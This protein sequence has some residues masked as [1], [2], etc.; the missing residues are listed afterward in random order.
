MTDPEVRV[1]TQSIE[2]D[3]AEVY[4]FLA[5]PRNFAKWASGLGA[6]LEPSGTEWTAQGPEGPVRIRF[7]PRNE[8][9]VLD[10]VVT[11]APGVEVYVPMRV[12]ANADGTG[13]LVT[14]TLFRQPGMSDEKFAADA[15]WVHRDLDTLKKLLEA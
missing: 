10:H 6:G 1:L 4:G 5:D 14:F 13:S 8:Y 12:T 3:R 15:D 2:R 7:A 11:V 9:G